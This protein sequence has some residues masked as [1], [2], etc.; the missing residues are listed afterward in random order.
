M[1]STAAQSSESQLVIMTNQLSECFDGNMK[2]RIIAQSF[3]LALQDFPDDEVIAFF[4]ELHYII[5]SQNF[6]HSVKTSAFVTMS[7]WLTKY[8]IVASTFFGKL[9]IRSSV[10][11]ICQTTVYFYAMSPD[12][13][14]SVSCQKAAIYLLENFIGW[15]D[16]KILKIVQDQVIE[17]LNMYLR[18]SDEPIYVET[19]KRVIE[20]W[21]AI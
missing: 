21:K 12:F 16:N 19:T 11:F 2:S 13:V 8:P 9:A 17:H 4:D 1:S 14:E 15:C 10:N 18:Y 3:A 20:L 6:S 7:N 5:N